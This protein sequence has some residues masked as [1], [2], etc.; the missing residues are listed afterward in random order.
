VKTINYCVQRLLVNGLVEGL[1]DNIGYFLPSLLREGSHSK[2][3]PL[4]TEKR[5]T[6]KSSKSVIVV[7]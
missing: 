1:V 3:R 7:K 6:K 4:D 2:S 5:V